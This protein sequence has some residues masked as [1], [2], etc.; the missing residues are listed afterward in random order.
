MKNLHCWP[1]AGPSAAAGDGAPAQHLSRLQV[2]A[3]AFG[4]PSRGHVCC[5]AAVSKFAGSS[6]ARARANEFLN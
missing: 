4:H 5:R 2:T 1:S 3:R 6:L